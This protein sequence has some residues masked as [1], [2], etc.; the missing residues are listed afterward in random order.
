MNVIRQEEKVGLSAKL[1][2][3]EGSLLIITVEYLELGCGY[4]VET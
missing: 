1:L 4:V 2:K 3:T